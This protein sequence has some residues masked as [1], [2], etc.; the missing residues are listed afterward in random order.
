[1]IRKILLIFLLLLVLLGM[2]FAMY[3]REVPKENKVENQHPQVSSGPLRIGFIGESQGNETEEKPFNQEVLIQLFEVLKNRDVHAIFFLGNMTLG[4]T[5]SNA[6][7][8]IRNQK[9]SRR[10]EDETKYWLSK[11]YVYD[12]QGFQDQLNHFHNVVKKYFPDNNKF[13]PLMG[14]HE[15]IG[16]DAA[17]I[18]RKEFLLPNSSPLGENMVAYTVS[19]QDV[20]F[21]IIPTNFYDTTHQMSIEHSVTPEMLKWLNQVLQ[22]AEKTHRYLFVLGHEPAFSTPQVFNSSYNLDHNP[23]KRDALWQIFKANSVLAYF[24][25]DENLFDR[26]IR[27]G[28]WQIITGGGGSSLNMGESNAFYHCILLTIPP[29]GQGVPTIEVL[30]VD[31]KVRDKFELNQK[32]PPVFQR[33]IL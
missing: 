23:E 32:E 9:S 10:E 26:S 24:A 12:S 28:V 6:G 17:L 30:D 4:W 16:P 15:A 3:L 1:M 29:N 19:I 11:G 31:G 13:Y 7:S 20:F 5:K 14:N 25:S 33:R 27:N 2:F 18:F 22:Q 21:V 8:E